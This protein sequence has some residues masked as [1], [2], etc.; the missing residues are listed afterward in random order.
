MSRTVIF[1]CLQTIREQLKERQ[2][3]TENIDRLG[4]SLVEGAG[5]HNS[6]MVA[7]RQNIEKLEKQRVALDRQVSL[8]WCCCCCC[9]CCCCCCPSHQG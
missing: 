9:S 1:I 2:T 8:H 4:S 5:V 6:A 3:E 7:V